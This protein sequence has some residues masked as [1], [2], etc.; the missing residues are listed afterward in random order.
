[1]LNFLGIAGYSNF[2]IMTLKIVI[3]IFEDMG[4][5]DF[6]STVLVFGFQM[7]VL[8]LEKQ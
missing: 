3:P 8:L 4:F 7:G 5:I 2:Y 6:H 1:M